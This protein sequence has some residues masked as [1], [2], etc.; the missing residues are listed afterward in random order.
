MRIISVVG[1]KDSGKTSLTVKIIKELKK[2]DYT[3]V[4]IKHSHHQMEMDRENTDTWKHKEAGSEISIGV[5]SRSFFNINEAIP[6]ERLLF[7]IKLIKEPDF[8]VIEG[9]KTY[10]YPKIATSPDVEDEY[11][12]EV[13]D[14]KKINDTE[15][16]NLV[17]KVEKIGYDILPTLYSSDCG[18][19]D[20]ESIGKA[21]VNKE[22][23]YDLNQQSDVCLSINDNVIGLN[24]F[25]SDFMRESII[26]MLKSLKTSEYGVEDFEKIEIIINK[27]DL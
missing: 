4:S 22:I 13:V 1:K 6:L 19:T 9:F 8:V 7:L 2:R 21:I 3:V 5:G 18:Y 25:V 12:I 27:K 14:A 10:N 16:E 24:S 20:G 11:T 15:V 26:G 17:D 23:E